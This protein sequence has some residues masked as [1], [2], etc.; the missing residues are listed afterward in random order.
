M[1]CC[2][3]GD[4]SFSWCFVLLGYRVS[5]TKLAS[6]CN[7]SS[8]LKRNI[9]R[10]WLFKQMFV[11]LSCMSGWH[12]ATRIFSACKAWSLKKK[13]L[14]KRLK[15]LTYV[16]FLKWNKFSNIYFFLYDKV[17]MQVQE[18]TFLNETI[19]YFS[20]A[21]SEQRQLTTSWSLVGS[22]LEINIARNI[23]RWREQ[24]MDGTC[25]TWTQGIQ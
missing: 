24:L 16:K 23:W 3:W 18:L 22:F 1:W 6:Q 14:I 9:L 15:E 11:M 17:R 4:L 8:F 5:C 21:L 7:N 25:K 19:V 12:P 13:N 2:L 20:K 10:C